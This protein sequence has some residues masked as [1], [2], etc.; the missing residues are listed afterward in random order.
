MS[1]VHRANPKSGL[2]LCGLTVLEAVRDYGHSATTHAKVEITCPECQKALANNPT[3][4]RKGV[5][6]SHQ[7]SFVR[8]LVSRAH[9]RKSFRRR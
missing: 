5:S 9:R 6:N 1:I 2:T 8:S 4:R 7:A 3:I